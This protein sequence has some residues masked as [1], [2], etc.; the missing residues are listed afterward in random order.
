MKKYFILALALLTLISCKKEVEKT[1]IT[2]SDISI[3]DTLQKAGHSDEKIDVEE[4]K[5][6]V[7]LYHN[8]AFETFL[9]QFG[10]DSI[11]QKEHIKYP[12]V[13]KYLDSDIDGLNTSVDSVKKSEYLYRDF[14][15]DKTAMQQEYDQYTIEITK[16]SD[17]VFY[18][19]KGYDNGIFMH[20]K[21]IF[22][23]NKWLL[24]EINDKST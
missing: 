19:L 15:E 16:P 4:T 22:K 14:T 13:W 11:F 21:F 1:A 8:E 6:E 18:T 17:T 2:E 12:L 10:A 20:Y 5:Q 9:D 7:E 3:E 24:V 23:D